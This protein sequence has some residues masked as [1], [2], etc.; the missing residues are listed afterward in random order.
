MI[1]IMKES[2]VRKSVFDMQ[3][4]TLSDPYPAELPEELKPFHYYF[5]N[6]G[7]C[8]MVIPRN[9]L[10]QALEEDALDDYEIQLPVRFVLEKGY[11]FVEGHLNYIVGNFDYDDEEGKVPV[12]LEYYEM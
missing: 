6:D 3:A 7:H 9:Y 1:D 8:L 5:A 2:A 11:S 12:P 4:F 10:K